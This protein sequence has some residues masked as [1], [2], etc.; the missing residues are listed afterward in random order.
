MD[1]FRYTAVMRVYH[2]FQ[3]NASLVLIPVMQQIIFWMNFASELVG[4]SDVSQ[5]LPDAS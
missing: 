3:I 5:T 1:R 4:N 2:N